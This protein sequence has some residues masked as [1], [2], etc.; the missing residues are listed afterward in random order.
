MYKP[1]FE[2]VRSSDF[3][4]KTT[5]MG[6]YKIFT[7]PPTLLE[8]ELITTQ[9]LFWSPSLCIN[10]ILSVLCIKMFSSLIFAL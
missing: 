10:K 8:G 3:L 6:F 7:F 1:L 4:E 9:I 5:L 2:N